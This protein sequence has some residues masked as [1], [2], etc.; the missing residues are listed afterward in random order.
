LG[1]IKNAQIFAD[2]LVIPFNYAKRELLV[3]DNDNI[4]N[5]HSFL[6][7]SKKLLNGQNVTAIADPN[8]N[9]SMLRERQNSVDMESVQANRP[10][11]V[12]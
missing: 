8:S 5:L 3:V 1:P 4:P 12:L 9:R 2:S 6:E 7:T 11:Q 10:R